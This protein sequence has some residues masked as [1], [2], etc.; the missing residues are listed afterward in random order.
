MDLDKKLTLVNWFNVVSDSHIQSFGDLNDG[1]KIVQLLQSC[2]DILT[3]DIVPDT[4][5]SRLA[6]IKNYLEAF[7]RQSFADNQI[8]NFD[9]LSSNS[10]HG[11][12]FDFEMGKL[13]LALLCCLVQE[14]CR[15]RFIDPAINMPDRQQHLIKEMVE[16]IVCSASEQLTQEFGNILKKPTVASGNYDASLCQSQTSTPCSQKA[17]KGAAG[18]ADNEIPPV[19]KM[20]TNSPGAANTSGLSIR[21]LSSP[22]RVMSLS[23]PISP[24]GALMQ[25]PQLA[26]K[27]LL[28]Q[29]NKEQKRLEAALENE[30]HLRGELELDLRERTTQ[31]QDRDIR[32]RDMERQLSEARKLRDQLDELETVRQE[33]E[34]LNKDVRELK[35]RLS[36]QRNIREQNTMLERE[37]RE[38]LQDLANAKEELKFLESVKKASEEYRAQCHKQQLYVSDLEARVQ[39]WEQEVGSL[40]DQLCETDNSRQV[41]V[42]NCNQLRREKEELEELLGANNACITGASPV[43]AGETMSVVTEKRLAE[44]QAKYEEMRAS[45]IDPHQHDSIRKQLDLEQQTKQSYEEKY[46]ET[47]RNAMSLEVDLEKTAATLQQ[48][49]SQVAS[50]E[51]QLKVSQE[52]IRALTQQVAGLTEAQVRLEGS[53][54]DLI[55]ARDG[56]KSRC[57]DLETELGQARSQLKMANKE[58]EVEK[59]VGG[60]VVKSLKAEK[61]TLEENHNDEVSKLKLEMENAKSRLNEKILAL[62]AEVNQR[63]TSAEQQKKKS[64][65]R[66]SELEDHLKAVKATSEERLEKIERLAEEID[67]L[68]K[69]CAGEID[70]LSCSLSSMTKEKK[71]AEREV[72]RLNLELE[73]VKSSGQNKTEGMEKKMEELENTYKEEVNDLKQSNKLVSEECQTLKKQLQNLSEKLEKEKSEVSRACEQIKEMQFRHNQV[74]G[75][76]EE[77]Q[78]N[79]VEYD[80]HLKQFSE[81]HEKDEAEKLTL[82]SQIENVVK[83][84]SSEKEK[85]EAQ[86]KQYLDDIQSVKAESANSKHSMEE[87]LEVSAKQ[88]SAEKEQLESQIK[89]NLEDIKAVKEELSSSAQTYES[90]LSAK[91]AEIC[92]LKEEVEA[93]KKTAEEMENSFQ[94]K[95]EKYQS[96]VE[97][98]QSNIM[99]MEFAMAEKDA[100][101]AS[102]SSQLDYLKDTE[103]SLRSALI[104]VEADNLAIKNLLDEGKQMKYDMH[105]AISEKETEM[106]KLRLNIESLQEET[107]QQRNRYS[108]EVE[109]LNQELEAEKVKFISTEETFTKL[110]EQSAA[111]MNHLN[112]TLEQLRVVSGDLEK[113]NSE[114]KQKLTECQSEILQAKQTVELL[115]AEKEQAA[116]DFK[117]SLDSVN[118]LLEEKELTENELKEKLVETESYWRSQCEE[119]EEEYARGTQEQTDEMKRQIE[120]ME[121]NYDD[122][123]L[124]LTSDKE[125]YIASQEEAF[126]ERLQGLE[127][128][129]AEKKQEIES[130]NVKFEEQNVNYR[131]MMCDM[132][133][134]LSEENEDLKSRFSQM[135]CQYENMIETNEK[136]TRKKIHERDERIKEFEAVKKSLDEQMEAAKEENAKLQAEIVALNKKISEL[137]GMISESGSMQ[138][139]R[140]EKISELEKEL[141]VSQ[142]DVTK[143]RGERAELARQLEYTRDQNDTLTAEHSSLQQQLAAVEEEKRQLEVQL[144]SLEAEATAHLEQAHTQADTDSRMANVEKMEL[145]RQLQ[146]TQKCYEVVQKSQTELEA[147]YEDLAEK[148]SRLETRCQ[149]L[150]MQLHSSQEAVRQLEEKG[151]ALREQI[152]KMNG[153]L[154]LQGD[155]CKRLTEV[156]SRGAMQLES[157]QAEI[158]SLTSKYDEDLQKL[159]EQKT[160]LEIS[161]AELSQ[162]A[163]KLKAETKERENLQNIND[164]YKVHYNKKKSIIAELEGRIREQTQALENAR[165]IEDKYANMMA[166]MTDKY[167]VEV[168]KNKKLASELNRV[169]AQLDLAERK[170]R[171]YQQQLD[172]GNAVF[173]GDPSDF[174][175]MLSDRDNPIDASFMENHPSSVPSMTEEDTV[176]ENKKRSSSLFDSSKETTLTPGTRLSRT[177]KR[178]SKS[179]SSSIMNSGN[180]VDTISIGSATS[181]AMRLRS[182][183]S[184]TTLNRSITSFDSISSTSSVPRGTGGL[185]SCEDEPMEMEWGRIGEL[186]RRNTMCPAHLKTSYPVETQRCKPN[187]FQ[188]DAL[189]ESTIGTRSRT[190]TDVTD[191]GKKRK[192]GWDGESSSDSDSKNKLAKTGCVYQKPGPPTP[193]NSRRNSKGSKSPGG[194]RLSTK[195]SKSPRTPS[196]TRSRRTPKRTPKNSTPRLGANENSGKKASNKRESVAFSIGFSPQTLD[197]SSVRLTRQQGFIQKQPQTASQA[198]RK[199]LGIRNY[200]QT[201]V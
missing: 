112:E 79:I 111:E 144:S 18:H 82:K 93:V 63:L 53:E 169:Q 29:K 151:T 174:Q 166:P 165:A 162:V 83:Q 197:R 103:K 114:I 181:L 12:A 124:R 120:E 99:E 33:N 106:S 58:L 102:M 91:D 146:A 3:Q 157:L 95:E 191:S 16:Y 170:L 5:E 24:L 45:W 155:E 86:I 123:M 77:A 199:P 65:E 4:S 122:K 43:F 6:A 183:E 117:A 70:D 76:L 21:D 200:Q 26:Q 113:E 73:N 71:A 13:L 66:Y 177:R 119:L 8:I 80:N 68:K 36:E 132:E 173:L 104:N 142:D 167:N 40:R 69:S 37:N 51:T 52:E 15:R 175:R 34:G 140:E 178:I 107:E 182:R 194:R 19:F 87:Q 195:S 20:Y 32:V 67:G 184:T 134:K 30:R 50:L 14:K 118:K 88:F 159:R 1:I 171:E 25:S 11:D 153:K 161:N 42:N 72:H 92:E 149:E 143:E 141:L 187:R 125:V 163:E 109:I 100:Q 127:K 179:V 48:A 147:R 94:K 23:S 75:D 78:K 108:A 139:E 74:S 10:L 137:E 168:A 49:Q 56:L 96:T 138:M 57:G 90:K 188:D 59:E 105:H 35:V 164:Q 47:K 101:V 84:F 180:D 192:Q 189:R 39:H 176:I 121:N 128:V 41:A 81:R 97:S 28:R 22:L 201:G 129:V 27:A 136:E 98:Q 172:K 61:Q 38:A 130:L 145:E 85:L 135:K 54:A 196:S 60:N 89:K 115:T 190:N 62:E 2:G 46:I 126:R 185:Y 110:K 156:N 31:I 154:V 186:S 7:Y 9:G 17:G 55:E 131:Q 64:S 150:E 158:A 133:E 116:V 44:V 152:S 193:A 160:T 198:L 148:R